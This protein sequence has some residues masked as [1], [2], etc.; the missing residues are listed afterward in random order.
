[1]A[2]RVS[3]AMAVYNGGRFLR[4]AVGSVLAQ[5]Y[6]DFEF[7]IVDD[8][9]TDS[10]PEIL[11]SY[12]DSRMV[13]I[14]NRENIGL[15]RSLNVCLARATGEYVA[16]MDADDICHPHRLER[17]VS[18]LTRH[19][20]VGLVGSWV[21]RIDDQGRSGGVRRLPTGAT[22][23][24]WR[25]LFGNPVAHPAVMFRRRLVGELGGYNEELRYAQD[26][27][28]WVRFSFMALP[29]NIPRPLLKLRRH[30]ASISAS[31]KEQQWRARCDVTRAA[32]ERI[33]GRKVPLEGIRVL[34]TT[35]DEA[36]YGVS[37][38]EIG[39]LAALLSEL[40]RAFCD[41]W[42]PGMMD[43]LPVRLQVARQLVLL[44]GRVAA[45]DSGTARSMLRRAVVADP[46]IMATRPF[47]RNLGKV[48]RN[49]VAW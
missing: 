15:T 31:H 26:H 48:V 13:V 28:M 49:G 10:T 5:T 23:L 34:T 37:S 12:A 30:S 44:A 43:L 47:Y 8:G 2:P 7:I 25:L 42:R 40:Y 4:E 29:A 11:A 16:R 3:I 41:Y 22:N 14:R 36:I 32:S 1:M 21:E 45:A 19:M 18:Y 33:L 6:R 46:R 20:Q 39:R 24:R 9:S 35:S 17:Q 27:E 38:G